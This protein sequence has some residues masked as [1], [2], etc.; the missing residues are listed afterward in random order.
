MTHCISG[1]AGRK[2]RA[3]SR[4]FSKGCLVEGLTEVRE[5]TRRGEAPG[6]SKGVGC[7]IPEP[8]RQAKGLV[9]LGPGMF[10][11]SEERLPTNGL[12]VEEGGH[13]QVF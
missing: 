10:G 2:Q 12:A 4:G 8:R 6:T 13:S 9:V 1:D 3:L 11:A 7:N 5:S